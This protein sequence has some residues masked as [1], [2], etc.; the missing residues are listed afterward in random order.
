MQIKAGDLVRFK[1]GLYQ[2]EDGL[3]YLVLEVN[4]DR[5]IIEWVNT[6]MT[7][8]PTSLAMVADLE[9]YMDGPQLKRLI[10]NSSES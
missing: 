6:K 5:S 10:N 3:I 9:I 7:I 8:R 4:G 2:E 1:K